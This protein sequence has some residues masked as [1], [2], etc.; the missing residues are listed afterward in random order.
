MMKESRIMTLHSQGK[1]GANISHSKYLSVRQAIHKV[2]NPDNIL[3]HT[4]LLEAVKAEL[5]GKFEGSIGWYTETVK[6]DLEARG[7]I[8]RTDSHPQGYRLVGN[9]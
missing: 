8:C 2:L 6:L 7:I 4:E 9:S 3:T 5:E 1:K